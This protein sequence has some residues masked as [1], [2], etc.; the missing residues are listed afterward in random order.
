MP[1]VALVRERSEFADSVENV[2]ANASGGMRILLRD[3]MP[4]FGNVLRC[5]RVEY[6][7]LGWAHLEGRWLSNFSSR[8]RRSSKNV[9][10]STGFTRPLLMSS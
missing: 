10:P 3:V 5:T 6:E 7:P 9:S 4:D 1:L 2:L 8:W